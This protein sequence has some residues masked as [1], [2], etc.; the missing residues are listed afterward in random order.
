MQP[1]IGIT[2]FTARHQVE[3]MLE[4]FKT[5]RRPG[6]DRLLH[7]GVMMSY[8]TL[9]G[10][11]SS[12]SKMFPPKEHIADIFSAKDDALYHCLHYADY[13]SQPELANSLTQAIAYGGYGLNAIQLDMVWPDPKEIEAA[14]AVSRKPVEVILQ[15][16]EEALAHAEND[17]LIL[18]DTLEQYEG[19]VHRVLI[20]KSGGQGRGMDAESLAPFVQI[21]IESFPGWGIGVAGGLG[22]NT[23]SLATP[24]AKHHADVLSIDAQGRLRPSGNAKEEPIHWDLAAEY[25]CEGLAMF[26]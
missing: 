24:L 1:Y 22:P 20:D 7:V 6:S 21:V 15:V 19:I 23:M 18:V 3:A 4:V 26:P 17:P 25:L 8:K 2:D 9:H 14:I 5:N 11:P 12:W 13:D 16:G 10:F